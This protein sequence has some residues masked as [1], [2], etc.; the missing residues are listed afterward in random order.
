MIIAIKG[1]RVKL[2]FKH[3]NLYKNPRLKIKSS[4]APFFL[5]FFSVSNS[6]T[7]FRLDVG[8]YPSVHEGLLALF[9]KP[10]DINSEVWRGPYLKNGRLKDLWG[11]DYQY[12]YP[13]IHNKDSFD[14]LSLGRD[15]IEGTVDDI[16]NWDDNSPWRKYYQKNKPWKEYWYEY[17]HVIISLGF[18]LLVGVLLEVVRIIKPKKMD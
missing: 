3:Y 2:F 15:G 16:N 12:T 14:L 4:L 17:Y 9:K 13:G 18:G 1:A 6:V 10:N 8:R 7:L 5:Y 11:Q